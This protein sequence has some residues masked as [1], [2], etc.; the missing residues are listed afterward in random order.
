MWHNQIEKFTKSLPVNF[1]QKQAIEFFW[2]EKLVSCLR[3]WNK[4]LPTYNKHLENGWDARWQLAGILNEKKFLLPNWILARASQDQ[5]GI[6]W[7]TQKIAKNY[8][9]WSNLNLF[10]KIEPLDFGTIKTLNDFREITG[11]GISHY[12]IKIVIVKL[13]TK[14]IQKNAFKRIINSKNR[15]KVN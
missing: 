4:E 12:P 13:A 8:V 2:N 6:S 10:V 3:T 14:L 7:H 9:D 11:L 1:L 15:I 5:D